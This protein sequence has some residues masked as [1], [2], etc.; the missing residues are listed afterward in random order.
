MPCKD[1]A[2]KIVVRL[3]RKECLLDFDFSK[4]TCS[5]Q[6]AGGTGYESYCRGRQIDEIFRVEFEEILRHF[7]PEDEEGRF[8]LYLEWDALRTSIAQYLGLEKGIDKERYKISSITYDEERVEIC[9]VIRPPR[10]MPKKIVSC[11][12]RAAQAES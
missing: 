11:A 1:T 8:F 10:E 4:I 6:I 7:N 5:K 12:V 9:Q 2:S 3:D